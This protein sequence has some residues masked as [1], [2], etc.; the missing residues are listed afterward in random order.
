MGLLLVGR[1]GDVLG[2]RYFLIGGQTLGLIGAV[3]CGTANNIPTIIGGSVLTGFAGAVQLTFTFVIAELVPNKARPAVN[4]G[5]FVSTFP[6][7]AFGPLIAQTFVKN[8][9]RQWRWSYYL[10]IITCASSAVLFLFFYFPPGYEQLHR[11][12]RRWDEVKK[13]DYGGLVLYSSGLVLVL[14]GLCKYL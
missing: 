10:N 4:S 12:Q 1:L 8:T 7:A 6:F 5:L 9:A 13:L 3:I 2:R 11:N 14:L